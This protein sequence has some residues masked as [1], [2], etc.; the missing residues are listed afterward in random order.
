M[1]KK[2]LIFTLLYDEGHF[3]LSRN[4]RLQR[5]GDLSWLN[6]NY[7]FQTVSRHIDE[8]VVLN[9]SRTSDIDWNQF[10][11]T[12][13]ALGHKNF[14]PIAVG[15]FKQDLTLAHELLRSGADKLVVNSAIFQNVGLVEDLVSR[16]GRQC[17]V[18]SIDIDFGSDG[19]PIVVLKKGEERLDSHSLDPLE[20]ICPELMGELMLR[21]V[22]RDGTGQGLD[23]ELINYLPEKLRHMPIIL[24]GGVGK[25]QHIID[26]LSFPGVSAVS[27]AN[28][29]NFIG[30]GL[31]EARRSCIESEMNLAKWIEWT[32]N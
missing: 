22:R 21:S 18:G 14:V 24:S 6:D 25:P 28:L 29:L 23:L 16:Y 11:E 13:R 10:L 7:N 4:F 26:G 19:H 1:P 3:V 27:T 20:S 2:R 30:T 31:E 12:V 32:N 5:I 9:V 17:V 15:G 8:L